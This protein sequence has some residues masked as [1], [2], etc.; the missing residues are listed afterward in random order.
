MVMVVAAVAR[1]VAHTTAP[2]LRGTLPARTVVCA[3]WQLECGA[4]S[5]GLGR[6]VGLAYPPVTTGRALTAISC[7][8]TGMAARALLL[9]ARRPWW[10]HANKLHTTAVIVV[11][12]DEA[13]ELKVGCLGPAKGRDFTHQ[14][15]RHRFGHMGGSW[16]LVVVAGPGKPP[17]CPVLSLLRPTLRVAVILSTGV[18]A[19]TWG[20][21][22]PQVSC[23]AALLQQRR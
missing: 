12:T 15:C 22:S 10:L 14:I 20:P 19:R 1:Q 21:L 18:P 17:Q 23:P 6:Y 11:I 9:V 13:V 7:A 5:V 3:G 4:P 2:R 16:L 8:F